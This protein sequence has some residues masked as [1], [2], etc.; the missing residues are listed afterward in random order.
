MSFYLDSR[1]RFLGPQFERALEKSFR[2]RS[3]SGRIVGHDPDPVV[4]VWEEADD[5]GVGLDGP[6]EEVL[7]LD[8]LVEVLVPVLD[9]VA[10]ELSP[11]FFSEVWDGRPRD[12]DRGRVEGSRA[13]RRGGDL[14]KVLGRE[15][16][17]GLRDGAVAIRLMAEVVERLHLDL[18]G[19]VKVLALDANN[20]EADVAE[21]LESLLL[22][23]SLGVEA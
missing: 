9:A 8:D 15:N 4:G 11:H 14:G 6:T 22:E 18:V 3:R 23:V 19:G 20:V 7:G 13:H 5:Q 10:D 12:V 17:L 21:V 2:L 1:G 16:L